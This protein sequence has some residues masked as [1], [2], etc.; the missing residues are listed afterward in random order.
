MYKENAPKFLD[1]AK[2]LDAFPL[3]VM[4]IVSQSPKDMLEIGYLTT[5]VMK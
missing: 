5:E 4:L 3:P 1:K 2:L